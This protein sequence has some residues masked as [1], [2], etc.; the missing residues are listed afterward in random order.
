MGFFYGVFM[1][2]YLGFIGDN[3]EG[4]KD[5]E[6]K[7]KPISD[8]FSA[9][10]F[11]VDLDGKGVIGNPLTADVRLNADDRNL[12]KIT[13][14]GL[15]VDKEDILEVL[16]GATVPIENLRGEVVGF[17]IEQA[18]TSATDTSSTDKYKLVWADTQTDE[19]RTFIADKEVDYHATLNVEYRV[20][21]KSDSTDFKVSWEKLSGTLDS[22][23]G[24]YIGN[25]S[26]IYF[27]DDTEPMITS[28]TSLEFGCSD[29]WETAPF[30]LKIIIESTDPNVT[31][32]LVQIVNWSG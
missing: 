18:D 15:L 3:G 10:S 30:Q 8:V 17:A 1:N 14:T 24:I 2:K 22:K 19:E 5:D 16:K 13:D 4:K 6:N 32:S 25:T 29:L 12:I 7:P 23:D 20:L 9:D 28:D 11:S 27:A 21:N 26:Y 31:G